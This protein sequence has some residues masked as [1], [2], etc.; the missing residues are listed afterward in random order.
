MIKKN[1]ENYFFIF[2]LIIPISIVIGPTVSLTNIIVIDLLFLYF[3]YQKKNTDFFNHYSIKLFI[4]LNLYLIFNTLIALDNEITLARNL[5]FIRFI[6]FFIFVNYFYNFFFQKKILGF[7][8]L[9]I[10]IVVFDIYFEF[11]FGSNLF[12]WGSRFV[13]GI[14]QLNGR[15]IT[16]FFKDEPVAGAFVSGF[17]FILFGYLLNKF[18]EKKLIPLLFLLISFIAILLT[19][20]RSNTIK[21][22]FG[23]MIFFIFS[24][25]IDFKKKI[26]SII[27]VILVIILS[28][29]N[30]DFLTNRYVGLI[31]IFDTKEKIND[32][33]KNNLY[34]KLYKSGFNIFKQ[35]P[36]FGVGNKNY[37]IKSCKFAF[38]KKKKDADKYICSTH[39]HQ[40]YFELLSE[41]GLIGSIIIL[42]IFFYIMF[43]I[44]REILISK[45]N[46]Q[47]GCFVFI[48]LNF[49]PILPSGAFFSDFNLT[50]FWLN[51]SLMFACN[52]KTNI[53]INK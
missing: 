3:F 31:K 53:F 27:I 5:G 45:N 13:D 10:S 28:I 1:I 50:I 35:Y 23:I 11:F 26:I 12:G 25:F 49:I 46:I 44:L 20:E 40:V 4:F 29:K 22:F 24:D 43:R 38:D 8:T 34:F 2:F 7:W 37:R 19:G 47:I 30:I 15:R 39:P 16:S 33:F 52:K 42:G 18:P 17:I 6:V 14:E 36:L 48:S 21:I 9:F 51:F 41:H 32:Q